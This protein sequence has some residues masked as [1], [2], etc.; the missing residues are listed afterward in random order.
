M[1]RFY[2]DSVFFFFFFFNFAS[3]TLQVQWMELDQK[4][5]HV[6]NLKI[7]VQNSAYHLHLKIGDPIFYVHQRVHNFDGKCL[8]NKTWY[9][10]WRMNVGIY[11]RSPTVS[12]NFVNFG[13]Q[14]T[15][16]ITGVFTQPQYSAS[17]PV[18]HQTC[19]KRH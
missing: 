17:L 6:W 1:F 14:M 3:A 10:Q 13:P 7:C 9:S 11:K 4:L 15:E 8:W 16:N 19:S 2:I 5:P 18:H 12:Q